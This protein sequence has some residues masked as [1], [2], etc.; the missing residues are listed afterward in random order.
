[1]LFTIVNGG[2]TAVNNAQGGGPAVDITTFKVGSSYNYTPATTDTALHGTALYSGTVYDYSTAGTDTVT[3]V[4][5]MDNTV[6]NFSFGEVGLY[7]SDG[8]LFALASL[9]NL[10]TKTKTDTAN[11]VSGDTIKIN[12]VCTLSGVVPTLNLTLVQ[13]TNAKIVQVTHVSDLQP[14][15]VAGA[16]AYLTSD[17]DEIGLPIWCLYDQATAWY[18]P[19]HHEQIVENKQVTGTSSTT[20]VVSTAIGNLVE[21]SPL[22]GKY[23]VLFTTGANAGLARL[24]TAGANN[25][26][27]FSPALSN[28][29]AVN[30]YFSILKS[31]HSAYGRIDWPNTFTQAMTLLGPLTQDIGQWLLNRTPFFELGDVLIPSENFIAYGLIPAVPNPA[32]LTLTMP[33]GVGYINGYRV[34]KPTSDADMTITFAVSSSYYVY[35]NSNGTVTTQQFTGSVNPNTG[36]NFM[37]LYVVYTNATQITTVTTNIAA[38]NSYQWLRFDK[39]LYGLDNIN[40]NLGVVAVQNSSGLAYIGASTLT[41]QGGSGYYFYG[42]QYLVEN[43]AFSNV[44]ANTDTTSTITVTKAF[45]GGFAAVAIVSS[46]I[47]ANV[48]K[49]VAFPHADG[50]AVDVII[51]VSAALSSISIEVI[52]AG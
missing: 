23:I 19:T 32:S 50:T 14:P 41:A 11:H 34:Y 21:A 20:T 49:L 39:V 10:Q 42:H 7:L 37:L 48:N 46:N 51:N 27:T 5:V 15:S 45:T 18:F 16:N 38:G 24:V 25:Q 33:T 22:A 28:A 44:A 4:C 13:A 43:F 52:C 2:I 3:F 17:T 31:N 47:A 8:T 36:S 1:M 9:P 40:Q 30:D 6:G 29:P 35:L 12:A 26:I